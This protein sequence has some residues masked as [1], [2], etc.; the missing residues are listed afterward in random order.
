VSVSK[1]NQATYYEN[2]IA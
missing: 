1:N 2:Q